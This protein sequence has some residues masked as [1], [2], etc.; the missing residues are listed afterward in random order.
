M[1][2]MNGMDGTNGDLVHLGASRRDERAAGKLYVAG[3]ARS[4]MRGGGDV[5]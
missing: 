1:A 2:F 4:R 3:S 5:M